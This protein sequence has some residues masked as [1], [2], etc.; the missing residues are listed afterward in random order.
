L[1]PIGYPAIER[2]RS[3]V[4]VFDAI[5]LAL[6]AVVGTSKGL[7]FHLGPVAA[8][9]LGMLTGIGGGLVRDVLVSDV[10]EVFRAEI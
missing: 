7:T 1:S 10:P 3:P 9:L 8:P 5:G 4:Q 2:L 6:F